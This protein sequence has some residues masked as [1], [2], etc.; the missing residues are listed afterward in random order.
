MMISIE[1]P[2]LA[3]I[4]AMCLMKLNVSFFKNAIAQLMKSLDFSYWQDS[5]IYEW[6][7]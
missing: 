3:A 2:P 6:D 4:P 7:E 1:E 5:P